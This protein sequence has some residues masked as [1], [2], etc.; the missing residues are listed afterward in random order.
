MGPRLAE[1]SVRGT[2][3]WPP[4]FFR[5]RTTI[6]SILRFCRSW[7]ILQVIL[8]P[9]PHV[10]HSY[11]LMILLIASRI[12]FV[13]LAYG[14]WVDLRVRRRGDVGSPC[15]IRPALAC[16]TRPRRRASGV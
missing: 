7:P 8:R 5:R 4:V 13:L 12:T 14:L 15:R 10:C 11:K 6:R 2:E 3:R 9:A 1:V 16:W